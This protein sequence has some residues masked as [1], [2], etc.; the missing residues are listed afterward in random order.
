MVTIARPD[1]REAVIDIPAEL[2]GLLRTGARFEVALELD[3]AVRA[4]GA[5]REIAPQADPVSRTQRVRIAL[6][7]SSA[8]LPPRHHG[9]GGA[10]PRKSSSAWCFRPRLCSSATARR[11][12]GWS[13]R[14]QARSRRVEVKVAERDARGFRVE[15]LDP[16]TR[17]VT[18]GVHSLEPGQAVRLAEGTAL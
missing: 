11:W 14:L 1:L 17:V 15:G 7:E 8:E 4:E 5:V 12:S 10:R 18:A 6:D 2:V 9:Q 3:P 13:I 16:G